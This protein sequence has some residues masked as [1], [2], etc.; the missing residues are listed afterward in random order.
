MNFY[1]TMSNSV[2]ISVI[3]TAS[4]LFPAFSITLAA[5]KH[6]PPGK[7]FMTVNHSENTI[8]VELVNTDI[9]DVAEMLSDKAGIN[10]FLDDS[11]THTVTSKFQ[12]LPLES[13]IKRILGPRINTAFVFVRDTDPSGKVSYY[14]DSVK[15]FNSGNALSANFKVFEKGTPEKAKAL[16]VPKIAKPNP[17]QSGQ[18]PGT[19][20]AI[21][22]EIVR[23]RKSLNMLRKKNNAKT[24]YINSQIGRL[25]MELSK[26]L[27]PDERA[28]RLKELNRADR[29][30]AK[31][32]SLNNRI[33]MDEEK[34][35][36][37]LIEA[38]SRTENQRRFAQRQRESE[39]QR[40]RG[41]K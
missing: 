38:K 18:M 39:K 1:R 9:S 24:A 15:M 10:I 28:E 5:E 26:K 7:Q 29:K 2:K 14:V 19:P 3:L 27:S 41:E 17:G 25:K 30:L 22:R 12:N 13:G 32:K 23:A 37:E 40:K 6:T 16:T 36:R 35:L 31:V 33:I 20:G 8:S 21:R 11:I 4:L 34:N